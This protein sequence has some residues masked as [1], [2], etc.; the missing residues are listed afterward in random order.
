MAVMMTASFNA[1]ANGRPDCMRQCAQ[2]LK[3]FEKQCKET[4]QGNRDGQAGC[5]LSAKEFDVQCRAMCQS[6]T[7]PRAPKN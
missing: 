2:T 3:A 4:V 5:A 6:G 1:F 7:K